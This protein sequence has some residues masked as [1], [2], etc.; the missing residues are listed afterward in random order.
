MKY[1]TRHFNCSFIFVVCFLCI[2]CSPVFSANTSLPFV[3]D[4]VHHNP[5][6]AL[7]ESQYNDPAVLKEMGYNGKVYF[8]FDSPQLAVDWDVIDPD[9]LPEGSEA[10]KWVQAKAERLH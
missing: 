3:W 9:I 2:S 4:M 7:Y 10:E 5:G 6:E 8:L 1:T